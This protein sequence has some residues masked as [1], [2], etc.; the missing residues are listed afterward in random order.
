MST[1][2]FRLGEVA[3]GGK[4]KITTSAT[5]VTVQALD[6]YTDKELQSKSFNLLNGSD[7]EIEWY[8]GDLTTSYYAGK[9]MDWLK[10]KVKFPERGW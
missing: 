6:Y 1:K 2:T 5:I 10:T 9:L 4:I 8:L 7:R 3:V